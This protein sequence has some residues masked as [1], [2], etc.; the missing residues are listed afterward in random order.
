MLPEPTLTGPLQVGDQLAERYLLL[1]AVATD[2]PT[3]LWR[4]SDE[5]LARPVRVRVLHTPTKTARE[6]AAPFLEA[7]VRTGAVNH[8]G[9]ARVYD[10][11]LETRPGRGNDVAYVIS[12]WVDGE[13]LDV[14]LAEVGALAGPDAADVLRQAAD[15][16]T[17]AH[18][19]GLLHGRVHPGNVLVTASGR[20]RLTDTAVAAALHGQEEPP[21]R[22]G[23]AADT[24]D[25]AAVLYALLTT[26]WPAAATPAPRGRLAPAPVADGHPLT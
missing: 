17:A 3:V 26:R 18:K 23:V 10:A 15:A 9:L 12:E 14:H 11:A 20:V 13:P 2:G 4:A 8:P 16:L 22:E 21:H 6:G 1:E 19:G 25:L 5:V 7:A 24:R